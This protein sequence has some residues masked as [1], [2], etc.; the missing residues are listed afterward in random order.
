MNVLR[1][2]KQMLLPMLSLRRNRFFP[3]MSSVA[4]HSLHHHLS[5]Q[6]LSPSAN[7]LRRGMSYR[8]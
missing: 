4:M 5:D 8:R 6:R 2:E 7:V 1:R 3:L